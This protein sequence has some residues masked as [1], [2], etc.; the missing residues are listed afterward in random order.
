MEDAHIAVLNLRLVAESEAMKK[1]RRAV[2]EG[3]YC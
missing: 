2:I 1:L 3:E